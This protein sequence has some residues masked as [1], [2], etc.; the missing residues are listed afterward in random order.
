MPKISSDLKGIATPLTLP[1]RPWHIDEGVGTMCELTNGRSISGIL[2]QP[3][4]S[5][6]KYIQVT[7]GS[8]VKA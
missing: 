5:D 3:G 1:L 4:F 8:M 2:E 7:I 6:G